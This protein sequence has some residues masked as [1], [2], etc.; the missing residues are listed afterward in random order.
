MYD[1]HQFY[2]ASQD[3]PITMYTISKSVDKGR[4]TENIKLFTTAS[5]VHILFFLRDYWCYV[6]KLPIPTE[7]VQW[8]KAK[9]RYGIDFSSFPTM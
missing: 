5:K 7:D 8:N 4:T 1:T 9:K 6:N 3:R 2:S